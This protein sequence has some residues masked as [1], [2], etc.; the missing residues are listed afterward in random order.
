MTAPSAS[1]DAVRLSST[2]IE[3]YGRQIAHHIVAAKRHQE[4]R[5][6]HKKSAALLLIAVKAQLP[7]GEYGKWLAVNG[8]AGSTARELVQYVNDPE[9]AAKRKA[10]DDA[11]NAERTT[12][13][14]KT[15]GTRRFDDYPSRKGDVEVPPQ[16][17]SQPP[18]Q[19]QPKAQPVSLAMERLIRDVRRLP[20]EEAIAHVQRCVDELRHRG[21]T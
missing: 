13:T 9:A 2:E 20:S 4:K 11:R 15:S 5:D 17:P 16:Q 10:Y 12:A 14:A 18:S 21:A 19:P 6:E 1:G 7:H 8:I 3:L